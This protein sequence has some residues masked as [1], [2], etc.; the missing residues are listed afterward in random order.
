MPNKLKFAGERGMVLNTAMRHRDF[1]Y[2]VAASS[3]P[4]LSGPEISSEI[5]ISCTSDCNVDSK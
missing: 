2:L 1:A 4:L 3:T 5:S